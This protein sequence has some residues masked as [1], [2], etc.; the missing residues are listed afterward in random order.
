MDDGQNRQSNVLSGE[1]FTL[2]TLGSLTREELEHDD[3]T[4]SHHDHVVK[5]G[6]KDLAEKI[7]AMERDI[8][9]AMT[10]GCCSSNNKSPEKE[11]DYNLFLRLY[12][13]VFGV[14]STDKDI[15]TRDTPLLQHEMML[16]MLEDFGEIVLGQEEENANDDVF[17]D[18][19]RNTI[20]RI[21]R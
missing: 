18:Q 13:R 21:V 20:R 11:Q 12:V 7:A 3:K 15:P 17:I 4:D 6:Q 9:A 16:Q 2:P 1:W 8:R 5:N 14:I 10:R 19:L